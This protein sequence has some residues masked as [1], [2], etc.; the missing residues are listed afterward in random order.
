MNRREAMMISGMPL[1][2]RRGFAQAPQTPPSEVS[3]APPGSPPTI[4]LKDYRPVSIYKIPS[5]DIKK[6][7]HPVFDV[8]CHGA[9]PI[10]RLDEWVRLMDTVGVERSVIFT[11]ASTPER[12]AEIAKPY[13]KYS[14]RFDLWCSFNL[15]GVDERGFG[16]NAVTSLED[17][18]RAGARGVG[19]LSDKG[20]GLGVRGTS[21][22]DARLGAVAR[23]RRIPPSPALSNPT[24]IGPHPDDPRLDA[25]F[26]KCG[27]LGMPVNI[28]VSDPVWAYQPMDKTNDGLMMS[29]TWRINLEPGMYDHNQLIES[30]ER[31]VKKHS[32]TIFVACHLANLDYDLARLGQMFE[33]NPNLF[34]DISARFVETATIPRFTSQFLQK[35]PDRVLYGTDLG[36]SQRMFSTTFRIL[37]SNDEHFYDQNLEEIHHWPL[38]GF[39]LPDDVLKKLYRDN[40]TSAFGKA[41]N[42]AA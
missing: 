13:E 24:D 28:H 7:R 11:G 21:P 42:S 30:L 34:A 18:H 2:W 29:W 41:Q 4:L 3:E 37:E 25:L 17:C 8:H 35:Y 23:D 10:E 31:A 6:A 40:A 12:F 22:G 26:A 16:P 33:R 14:G 38:S 9:R 5:S 19:E 32:K 27:Q 15:T 1:A 20:R 39:G 36:Y